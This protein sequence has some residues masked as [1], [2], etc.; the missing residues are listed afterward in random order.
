M[1]KQFEGVKITLVTKLPCIQLQLRGLEL[2]IKFFL[3]E[4][5]RK[6]TLYIAKAEE[7]RKKYDA[8]CKQMGIE[9]N[10]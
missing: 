3:K 10:N 2:K 9:V 4:S 6:Q 8:T 5:E 1:T 7:L